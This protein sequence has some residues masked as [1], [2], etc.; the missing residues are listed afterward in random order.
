VPTEPGVSS[1]KPDRRPGARTRR[2]L[3]AVALLA[4]VLSPVAQAQFTD[5]KDKLQELNVRLTTDHYVLAGTVTDARLEVYARALEY[6]HHEYETG[7]AEL[8]DDQQQAPHTAA[9]GRS[10][11]AKSDRARDRRAEPDLTR[12]LDQEDEQ[13]RFPVIVF[14]NRQQYLDFGEAFLSGSEHSIGKYI[15]S[16]K[17]LLILD[18]GNFE[19]TT[20]VLFHEAFHQFL[21]RYVRNPPTWIDEGL[22][23]HYG[24][25]RPTSSG[26][27]FRRPPPLRWK[28]VRKLIQTKQAIPLWDVVSASQSTFYNPVPVH[29]SGFE[30]VTLKS[31]YYAEAY[32]LVH[33][34]LS[35]RSGRE[36]LCDYLRALADDDGRRA[37]QITREYFGPEVCEHMMPF[38]IRHVESRPENR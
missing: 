17:L 33:T 10:R 1:T 24:N 13:A 19:D 30:N 28:L 21:H 9:R 22:A 12:T 16:C 26:L 18:Q 27:S 31:I 15:P 11:R 8:L 25:A 23:T 5:L 6:I 38:W 14:N 3:P 4:W 29:V 35:D 20:E 32:T 34:L 37:A 7:F 2:A 36:R